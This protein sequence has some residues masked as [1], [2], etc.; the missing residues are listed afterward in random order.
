MASPATLPWEGATLAPTDPTT[1]PLQPTSLG[2]HHKVSLSLSLTLTHLFCLAS[3]CL[4]FSPS[5]HELAYSLQGKTCLCPSFSE[6]IAKSTPCLSHHCFLAACVCLDV[7][8]CSVNASTTIGILVA[9]TPVCVCVE[10][11]V[12]K[13]IMRVCV[14]PFS[15]AFYI[16]I[17]ASVHCLFPFLSFRL[18]SLCQFSL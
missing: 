14:P 4:C 16:P 6:P 5:S 15:L 1:G 13:H 18:L 7:V 11:C 3:D 17:L 12:N 2:L 9:P 8:A 10:T